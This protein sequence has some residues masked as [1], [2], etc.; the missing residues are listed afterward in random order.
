MNEAAIAVDVCPA[1]GARCAAVVAASEEMTDDGW[2]RLL[3]R[4]GEATYVCVP[5]HARCKTSVYVPCLRRVG[6]WTAITFSHTQ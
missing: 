6:V 5:L 4:S 3:R 1:A 2:K